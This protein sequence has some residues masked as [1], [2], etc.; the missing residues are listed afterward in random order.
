M[1]NVFL[2]GMMGSGKTTTAQELARIRALKAIDVDGIIEDCA[3]KSIN[4]IFLEDGEAAFR[5]FEKDALLQVLNSQYQVVA[6]GGGIV[7]APENVKRMRE[8]GTVV[9]LKTALPILWERVKSSRNRPLLR[10]ENPKEI[11][12][13]IFEKRSALYEQAAHHI[14]LT[15]GKTVRQVASEIY[16]KVFL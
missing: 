8:S 12:K 13:G 9:Y 14:V 6:T 3:K 16:E 1:N 4:D 15:D 5:E 11:F 10:A 7:L 2:I